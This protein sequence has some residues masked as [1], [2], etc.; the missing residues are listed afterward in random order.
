MSETSKGGCLHSG[1]QDI[2]CFDVKSTS[3][4]SLPRVFAKVGWITGR[5]DYKF[6]L[7]FERTTCHLPYLGLQAAAS[8]AA[9]ALHIYY[10]VIGGRFVPPY[11]YMNKYIQQKQQ[12][13]LCLTV[14][15]QSSMLTKPW[16]L[17]C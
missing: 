6:L 3:F 12:Q 13:H 10:V 17:A 14:M 8:A 7:I 4:F 1:L 2:F 15:L 9:S 16:Q 5:V 11:K